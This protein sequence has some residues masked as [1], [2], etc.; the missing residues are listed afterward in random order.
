MGWLPLTIYD[1]SQKDGLREK[2]V[3]KKCYGGLDLSST[4]DLTAFVLLFPP[5]VG[6]TEWAVLFWPWITEEGM[7]ERSQR[8]HV[9]FEAWVKAGHVY[10]TPGDCVDFDFVEAEIVRA[11]HTYDLRYVGTDPHLSRSLTQRLE[12]DGINTI[13]IPQTMS[14]MSP[15]MK[16]LERHLRSGK[17]VHEINPC[18]R[19]CFGNTRCATDGN[20]N[21]KPMKNRS[22]GR[23]DVTVA[24][25]IAMGTA[26]LDKGADLNAA[27]MSGGWGM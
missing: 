19:W 25:I 10:A 6:L 24:W 13:E 1:K 11:S 16:E 12:K 27:I 2:L 14:G 21:I 7:R 26:M 22:I 15:P 4:T 18:A 8:D 20:E 23:I 17:M 3:G 5:Q 9:D